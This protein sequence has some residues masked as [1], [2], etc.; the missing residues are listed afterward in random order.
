M[1]TG[2]IQAVGSIAEH[3]LVQGD[4]RLK[5][6]C[7][8]LS[9]QGRIAIGDSIAVNGVCLTA[10]EITSTGFVADV[11]AE[12]LSCT[13]LGE[14]RRGDRANLELALLPTT[15]LGGHL[16]SG[17]V[18]GVGRVE[19]RWNDA[20]SCRLRF[21]APPALA[22]FVAAK[23]SIS[24]DGVSLTVNTVDAWNA[25]AK[26][27]Q[28]AVNIVPH[29]MLATTMGDYRQGTRVHLEVDLVARYLLRLQECEP[30]DPTAGLSRK[31]LIDHGFLP[32]EGT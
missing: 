10:V 30:S 18:D 3:R 17:H 4:L 22:R 19:Q 26:D 29:T 7:S 8:E 5:V 2:I 14:A 32:Q 9:V 6:A 28:F 23:G 15:H 16:V 25:T 31:V 13:L 20:R 21:S 12:T 1:F 24:I 27:C 11:S